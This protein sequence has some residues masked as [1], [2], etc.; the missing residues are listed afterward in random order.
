MLSLKDLWLLPALLALHLGIQP[1]MLL[2]L[3]CEMKLQE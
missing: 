3:S 2:L 1:L